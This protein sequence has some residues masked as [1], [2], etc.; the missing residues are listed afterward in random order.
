MKKRIEYAIP[1][2]AGLVGAG[3]LMK[4]LS[5]WLSENPIHYAYLALASVVVLAVAVAVLAIGLLRTRAKLNKLLDILGAFGG[6]QPTRV[7]PLLEASA[8]D[9]IEPFV[10]IPPDAL[11]RAARIKA[12]QA[13]GGQT[14]EP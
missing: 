14:E 3:L 12:K 10:G 1:A 8:P 6:P 5:L 4:A 9:P 13:A 11:A 7:V 2:V